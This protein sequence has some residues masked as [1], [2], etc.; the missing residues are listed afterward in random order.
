[1]IARFVRPDATVLELGGNV[2]RSSCV[3]ASILDD[4]AR[5]VVFESDPVTAAQLKDNRDA[6]GMAF[7]IEAAA[8]SRCPLVQFG[9]DT[10]PWEG[11][12][13]EPVPAGWTRVVT[14]GWRQTLD[15]YASLRFDTLVADCEGALFYI[16]R[17]H[18]GFLDG[19][20]T[21][22]IE[23]DFRSMEHKAYCDI[24]F[25]RHGFRVAYSEAGGWGPCQDRFYEVW[26]KAD[27][28][29]KFML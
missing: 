16:L 15:T 3:I 17:D 18:P 24:T 21:V 1:M 5:L 23:N 8:L 29:V 7:H 19:F 28:Q 14:R 9:W 2:G 25:A 11:E 26:V 20:R 10:V 22:L 12:E 13:D 6:N 27:D 4:S